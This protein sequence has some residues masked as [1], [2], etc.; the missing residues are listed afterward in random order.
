MV[1]GPVVQLGS[2]SVTLALSRPGYA[3]QWVGA[4]GTP[5]L[6]AHQRTPSYLLDTRREVVPYR[7]RPAVERRL[8]GWLSD[9]A[10]MSVLLVHGA[11]GSGK[12]RL[13][14]AFAGFAHARGWAVAQA[15][16]S[17]PGGAAAT[18]TGPVLVVV[19]YAER[20]GVDTLLTMIGALPVDFPGRPLRVLLLARSPAVWPAL[21]DRLDRLPAALPEPVELGDLVPP[22]DRHR[23]FTDAARA[24]ARVLGRPGREVTGP[25]LPVPE[26]PV[27]DL[28][29]PDLSADEYGSALTLHMAALAAAYDGQPDPAGLSDYLLRH[30]GRFW[31]AERRAEAATA[32][33]LATLHGPLDTAAA[34]EL[35]GR[36]GVADLL[37]W[38]ASLYPPPSRTALVPL[39]PDRFGED[40]VAR[41]LRDD[42]RAVELFDRVPPNRRCLVVLT[43]A[44]ERHEHVREVLFGLLERNPGLADRAGAALLELV[45]RHASRELC[46][47]V[48][49]RQTDNRV[50]VADVVV[51][52]T[53]RVVV[54]LPPDT[55]AAERARLLSLL[56]VR[57][58]EVGEHEDAV[59]TAREVV[60]IFERLGDRGPSGR[61]TE[62]AIAALNLG[63]ALLDAGRPDEAIEPTLR[64][65]DLFRVLHEQDGRHWLYVALTLNQLDSVMSVTGNPAQAVTLGELAVD[66]FR[67]LEGPGARPR[68]AETL[69]TSS[70]DLLSVGRSRE[71]VARAAEAVELAR[72]EVAEDRAV[73]LDMLARCV[74]TLGHVRT[75]A[76]DRPGALA[77]LAEA[78]ELSREL[79]GSTALRLPELAADLERFSLVVAGDDK[80]RALA[81][82]REAVR[83]RRARAATDTDQRLLDL[84]RSL[85]SLA[86]GQVAAGPRSDA[87]PEALDAARQAVRIHDRL[88]ARGRADVEALRREAVSTLVDVLTALG[89]PAE[90]AAIREQLEPPNGRT[91]D[92]V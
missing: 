12:T 77:A 75:V 54:G 61:M 3:L 43:A 55:P 92:S 29:V 70:L 39:R 37:D 36:A 26:L 53:R 2:G 40:F 79:A 81:S 69:N 35:L 31:P 73:H 47:L 42:P 87:L 83:I 38:H 91:G 24:F 89:R 86:A 56:T 11:G 6:P 59:E 8:E 71:A 30:E 9:D 21:A 66:A 27:P 23:A 52:L 60:R 15:V 20:W 68:L 67:R 25:D 44:A 41:H 63:R 85:W 28:P 82:A 17:A 58:G 72:L 34:R 18:G 65:A 84:A 46:A 4:G 78:V 88:L 48:L 64:A 90:A 19:D 49:D 16:E 50:E 76:G 1:H 32:V 14:N 10:P 7:S 13:A 22:A 33:F 51:R 62:A 80:G 57:L 74:R 45:V 5:W